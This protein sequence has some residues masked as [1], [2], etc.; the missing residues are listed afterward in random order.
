MLYYRTRYAP[1]MLDEQKVCVEC[2]AGVGD[3]QIVTRERA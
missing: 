1:R 3:K 2:A